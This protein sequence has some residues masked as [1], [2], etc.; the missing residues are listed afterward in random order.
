VNIEI[1]GILSTL[2]ILA[3]FILSGET[4]IRSVNIIGSM[5]FVIYGF[6]IGALSVWLLNGILIFIHIYKLIKLGKVKPQY[7]KE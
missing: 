4:K 6:L 7:E 5:L 3:S 2:F 1:L